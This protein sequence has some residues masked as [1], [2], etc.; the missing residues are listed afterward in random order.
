MKY[1][2]PAFILLSACSSV[3][4]SAIRTGPSRAANAGPVS[5]TAM[6]LPIGA[7]QVGIVVVRGRGTIEELAPLFKQRVAEL[8]G[9]R[10]LIDR[11]STRYDSQT[12]W[13]NEMYPCGFRMQTTC[14]R[15]VP[16]LDEYS[17]LEMSG[18]AFLIGPTP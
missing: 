3:Q 12:T 1:L 5:L 10:G 4:S 6:E 2:V 7:T 9:N 18:R 15:V 11:I 8:G 13:V 17:T 14:T 16:R